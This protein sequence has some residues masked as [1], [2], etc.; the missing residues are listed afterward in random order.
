MATPAGSAAP[1]PAAMQTKETKSPHLLMVLQMIAGA[2]A[3]AVAKTATAPL[4]RI[5][6]IFQVQVSSLTD[7]MLR[8]EGNTTRCK[9]SAASCRASYSYRLCDCQH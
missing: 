4:E 7:S 8:F 5:K 9:S 1:S 2:A 6:I 3:G